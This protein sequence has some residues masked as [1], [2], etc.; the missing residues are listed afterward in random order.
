[1]KKIKEK[2][3]LNKPFRIEEVTVMIDEKDTVKVSCNEK[4]IFQFVFTKKIKLK[5]KFD[6]IGICETN[7]KSRM[8]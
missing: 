1:M 7:L 3:D 5:D 6:V 2:Q 8:V 4:L